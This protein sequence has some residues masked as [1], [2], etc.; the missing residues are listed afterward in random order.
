M[1]TGKL[2]NDVLEKIILSNIKLKREEV[3]QGAGIGQDNAMLDLEGDLCVLSTDPITGATK[4]IGSLVVHV[5]SND[6]SA[7]GGEAVGI[8]ITLLAPEGTKLEE[9]SEIMADIGKT[10]KELNIQVIGGH[11]EVTDAVNRIVVNGTVIG[12]LKKDKMPNIKN[13]KVGDKILMTKYAAI[14]GTA[15]LIE[16]RFKDLSKSLTE[17]EISEA[18]DLAKKVSVKT[19]GIT[20]GNIGVN[21]MHDVTE[22]GML[23]ALWEA[24]MAI[25]KGIKINLD[26][27]PI[28]DIS[29]KICELLDI[30]I[31][32]LISSGS[33]LIISPK[34]NY[35]KIIEEL[36]KKDILVTE[37]GEVT[38]EGLIM[39]KNGE[40][41][42]I[43]PPGVDEL[44][45][46]LE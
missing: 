8:L 16:E 42:E 38:E 45:K 46:A 5:C 20:A 43:D 31:Y 32:K 11:T 41:M 13:V 14:E 9:L 21:Y 15:I 35:K 19:E 2:P 44:Y 39:V 18:R 29:L 33:M 22:G 3:L 1:E 27:I 10:A 24:G 37:I 28:K 34:E 7:S 26:A 30:D 25:E 40:T 4:N 17:K 36:N 12:R 23:G 6:I